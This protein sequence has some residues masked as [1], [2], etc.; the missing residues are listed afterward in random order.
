MADL[1]RFGIS[2]EK[3]LS[4]KF[5]KFIKDKNYTNRSEAIRD[6]V[7]DAFVKEAWK[8]NKNVSGAITM[9]YNHHQRTLVEKLIS[10][11]HDHSQC[12]VSSQHVHL[13]HHDCLEVVV[14]KG[15][16]REIQKLSDK[17]NSIK[18]VKHVSLAMASAS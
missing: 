17:L 18:G 11:Q 8:K 10:I 14:V 1:T 16:S 12:I 9:I 2:I 4:D 6:L 5:D 13:N 15:I 3:D 7:R